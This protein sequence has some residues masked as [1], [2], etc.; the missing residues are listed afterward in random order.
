LTV[1]STGGRFPAA[2]CPMAFSGTTMPVL[3]TVT[4][5]AAWNVTLPG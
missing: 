2:S 3:L 5:T 1:T 4:A